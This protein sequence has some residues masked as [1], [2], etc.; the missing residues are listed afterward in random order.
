MRQR[1]FLLTKMS[2]KNSAHFFPQVVFLP[3]LILL[4]NKEGVNP[5]LIKEFEGLKN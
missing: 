2:V 5:K 1:K 3:N 4:L